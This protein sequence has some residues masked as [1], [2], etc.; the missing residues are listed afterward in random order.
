MNINRLGISRSDTQKSA[1][2]KNSSSSTSSLQR[3]KT[4]AS[5]NTQKLVHNTTGSIRSLYNSMSKI[6]PASYLLEIKN[7]LSFT[8]HYFTKILFNSD[9]AK[10]FKTSAGIYRFKPYDMHRGHQYPQYIFSIQHELAMSYA[11]KTFQYKNAMILKTLTNFYQLKMNLQIFKK[12]IQVCAHSSAGLLIFF[13][14]ATFRLINRIFD[15]ALLASGIH[16][17]LSETTEIEEIKKLDSDC[18]SQTEMT[19][20]F[21]GNLRENIRQKAEVLRRQ[22]HPHKADDKQLGLPSVS[23]SFKN[24][25]MEAIELIGTI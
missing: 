7:S 2:S 17:C 16:N 11:E 1:S 14:L 6:D 18:S 23:Q 13:P 20:E 22:M 10:H 21:K 19:D 25:M 9:I 24:E 12:D 3:I 5:T 15:Q 4:F 8:P